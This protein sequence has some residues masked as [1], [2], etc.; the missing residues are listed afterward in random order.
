VR[1]RRAISHCHHVVPV[2]SIQRQ[3]YLIRGQKVMLDQDLGRL[4]G[5]PT[6]RLNEA[7][8]RNASRFPPDFMLQ[9]TEKEA[10]CL[11]SQFATS[12][13]AEDL[14][15]SRGRGGRRTWPYAFTEHGI[16]M[17]SSVL[18]S[19]RAVQMNILIIR[20]FIKLRDLLASHQDLANRVESL[21]MSREQ[22]ASAISILV[23]EIEQLKLPPPETPKR[24]IGF[25]TEPQRAHSAGRAL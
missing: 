25:R 23:D 1:F 5:V 24:R 7:V 19:E 10:T 2:E 21:E 20:A 13:D 3:I 9:L 12:N 14:V 18:R 4:Y 22:H 15:V 8:R 17:L 6:K 11:R 16:A